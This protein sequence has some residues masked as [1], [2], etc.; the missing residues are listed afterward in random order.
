VRETVQCTKGNAG[1]SLTRA[2][3]RR[4]CTTVRSC[5]VAQDNIGCVG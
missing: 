5:V 3:G 1:L 4:V 2:G